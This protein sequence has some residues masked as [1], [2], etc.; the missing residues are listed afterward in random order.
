MIPR[1]LPLY[2]LLIVI[3][4]LTTFDSS[5]AED[6]IQPNTIFFQAN[7]FYKTEQYPQA[8]EAY[9]QLITAGVASGHLFYNLGNAYIKAG[10]TGKA[11]LNYERAL[12]YLPRDADVKSNLEYAR[13][14]IEGDTTNGGDN[15]LLSRVFFLEHYF[16]LNELT[17]IV[18]LL[19][20]GLMAILILSILV[21]N[22]RRASYYGIAV[23]GILLLFS[24]VCFSIGL[25]KTQFQHRAVITSEAIEARF[26]PS[27]DAT[28]HF[29]LHEGML[30][31]IA[32]HGAEWSKIRRWDGK[33]GW[34]KNHAFEGLSP[35][36][37]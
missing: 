30:I 20:I 33:S 16:N 17:V 3:L 26:E 5:L 37:G 12:Q 28:S 18:S 1:Q 34:L 6:A 25:H 10:S 35:R 32:E 2:L 7:H 36:E 21:S 13:S 14:L 8:I 11:V 31:E 4:S 15:W 9:E 29:I 23:F 19:Y 22:F 24:I 27:D